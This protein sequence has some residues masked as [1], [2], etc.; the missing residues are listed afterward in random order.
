MNSDNQIHVALASDDN[1]FEGLLTTAWSIARNCSRPK[2]LVFHILDGGISDN[3]WKLL[4]DRLSTFHC[5]ID[6]L[7]INQ[8]ENFASFKAY[9]GPG[10]MTYARLLLPDLL[11]QVNTV[12]Y[13]DVD[14]AWIVD[15][16]ELWDA[17][18][19]QAVL[20]YVAKGGHAIQQEAEWFAR[21]NFTLEEDK[22]FCAAM[23]V[24]NLAQFRTEKLHEAMLKSIA[25]SNGDVPCCDE[26]ALNAFM[27]GRPDRQ[28][29]S[30]RWLRPSGG[31]QD[32][33]EPTGFVMHFGCDAPWRTLHTYHHMLTD[34]HVI[35]HKF[36]AEARQISTWRSLRMFN[37]VADI[38]GCR[39]LFLAASQISLVR[40]LVHLAMKL[41]GNKNSFACFD[42]YAVKL[43]FNKVDKHLIP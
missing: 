12:I 34:A 38:I 20:H 23:I 37:G 27:F 40:S 31:R 42:A 36:H 7:T 2:D 10:K 19:P 43:P 8:S 15:I 1:Y 11:P 35:W 6:R 5:Q 18:N 41:R 14:M 17:L 39:M 22:R 26:T 28:Q 33:L 29:I 24:M 3:R 32:D 16:C 21:N 13:S 4:V 25:D 9:R 30:K